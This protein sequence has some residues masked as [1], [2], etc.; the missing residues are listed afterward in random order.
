MFL[1]APYAIILIIRIILRYHLLLKPRFK[2]QDYSIGRRSTWS[3]IIGEQQGML[4]IEPSCQQ[5]QL[6]EAE[7][8]LLNLVWLIVPPKVP[9]IISRPTAGEYPVSQRLGRFNNLCDCQEADG[10]VHSLVAQGVARR[11]PLY[12]S[13]KI[14]GLAA[15]LPVFSPCG[16]VYAC[17]RVWD[18]EFGCVIAN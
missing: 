8:L 11:K 17:H 12:K 3:G 15:W 14:P 9:N 10:T 2:S 7:P 4:G 1:V 18:F 16:L 13:S 5:L 6:P